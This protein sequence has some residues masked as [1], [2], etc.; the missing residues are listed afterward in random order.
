MAAPT[1]TRHPEQAEA[2]GAGP[3]A[4]PRSSA[5]ALLEAQRQRMLR[6]GLGDGGPSAGGPGSSSASSRRGTGWYGAGLRDRLAPTRVL[7]AGSESVNGCALASGRHG[8][9]HLYSASHSGALRVHSITTGEQVR[10]CRCR[11]A[12]ACKL[13]RPCATHA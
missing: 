1:I 10:A 8:E 5:A 2:T 13:A 9:T 7:V 12:L 6:Q 3:A 11:H 4:S